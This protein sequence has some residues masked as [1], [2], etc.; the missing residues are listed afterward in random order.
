MLSIKYDHVLR[1]RDIVVSLLIALIL[2][3]NV[4]FLLWLTFVDSIAGLTFLSHSSCFHVIFYCHKSLAIS[5]S[6]ST[7]NVAVPFFHKENHSYKSSAFFGSAAQNVY[8][9]SFVSDSQTNDTSH[10]DEVRNRWS[11]FNFMN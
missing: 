3:T 8:M 4:R 2:N 1:V 6:M 7:R 5:L 10:S 9:F 11:E